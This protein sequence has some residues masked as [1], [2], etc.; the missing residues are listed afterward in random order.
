MNE[1]ER[2]IEKI[3][4]H[5]AGDQFRDELAA[6]KKEFFG[7]INVL[8][9]NSEQF[10]IRM[11]QFYDWYF[12]TR[13][14]AGYAM[15]P[16]NACGM[17]RELR[18]SDEEKTLLEKLKQNRHSLFQFQK[19]KDE[20]IYI[21]DLFTN[22]KLVVRRSPWIYG[23]DTVEFFEARLLP[24]GETYLFTRGF[25]FHPE[26]ASKYILDE[27]KRHRKDPDL[28]PEDFML[29]LVKMRYKFEQYRHLQPE[30]IYSNDSKV[31]TR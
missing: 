7:N 31:M 13:P 17:A 28:N 29:R 12:F 30:M 8:E 6:A 27:I 22:Q 16:L 18:F 14:L 23:F 5:F 26:S 24:A 3:L 19:I 9:E 15:T 25:C 21:K 2:L 20:D 11:A 4:Q 10:E 1:F